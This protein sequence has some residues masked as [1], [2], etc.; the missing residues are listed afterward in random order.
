MKVYEFVKYRDANGEWRWRLVAANGKRVADSAEGYKT[1][2]GVERA[3]D[4]MMDA[5]MI[6][7]GEDE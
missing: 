7:R 3:I 2:A 6:V 1:K 4:R 5:V